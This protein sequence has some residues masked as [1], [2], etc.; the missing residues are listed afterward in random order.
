M[1]IGFVL[2][3]YFVLC[4]GAAVVCSL[5]LG[6]VTWWLLRRARPSPRNFAVVSVV[7]LPP[8]SVVCGL[9]GFVGY[10]IWCET[11]R[12][13]DAGL[14]DS[15]RVPLG[16]GYE[17]IMVDTPEQAVIQTPTRQQLGFGLK[18]LG[19]NDLT[20]Y[21]ETEHDKFQLVEK[22]SGLSSMGLSQAELM[23]KL[24]SLGSPVPALRP[25]DR[26]YQSLRWGAKDL[27]AIPMV[28][29]VP[30]LLTLVVLS[31]IRRVRRKASAF[32]VG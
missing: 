30:A 12:G 13:V 9:L 21:F 4:L 29:G 20:I 28:F 22:K 10:G 7:L 2:L 11:V 14:G 8:V 32:V 17:L 18:R 16:S 31:Y 3:V 19:Y 23:T 24:Q 27:F 25:P 6:P 5:V 15:W 1:G 26:V